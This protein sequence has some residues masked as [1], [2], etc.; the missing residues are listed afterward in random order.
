MQN[1]ARDP[2]AGGPSSRN[3]ASLPKGAELSKREVKFQGLAATPDGSLDATVQ[4]TLKWKEG[5]DAWK[6]KDNAEY[7]NKLKALKLP[8]G[9]GPSG[10]TDRI[11]SMAQLLGHGDMYG[12]RLACIGYLLPIRAHSLHEILTAASVYGCAFTDGKEIYRNII[13]LSEAELRACGGGRFPDEPK[14]TGSAPPKSGPPPAA[15]PPSTGGA[16]KP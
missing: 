9:A 15:G 6:A 7:V 10:T 16:K 8:F 2:G 1:A 4:Q 14:D 13:P 11:M 12:T 5:A 3:P